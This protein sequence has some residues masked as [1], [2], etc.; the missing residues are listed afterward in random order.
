M[1]DE[2]G[3]ETENKVG[4]VEE[5][6]V[7]EEREDEGEERDAVACGCSEAVR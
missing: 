6:D 7:S 5:K 3:G 1:A 4:F 2:E